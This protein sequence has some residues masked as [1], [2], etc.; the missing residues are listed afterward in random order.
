MTTLDQEV[1]NRRQKAVG[2]GNNL[3]VL[4]FADDQQIQVAEDRMRH[5]KPVLVLVPLH[6]SSALELVEVLVD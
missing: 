3:L 2:E 1:L 6:W 5:S 4:Y